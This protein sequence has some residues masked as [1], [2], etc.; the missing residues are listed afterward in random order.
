MPLVRSRAVYIS[1]SSGHS[2]ATPQD[3]RR[4]R[5]RSAKAHQVV[6]RRVEHDA[7]WETAAMRT[8]LE[9]A[10]DMREAAKRGTDIRRHIQPRP[11]TAPR[12]ERLGCAMT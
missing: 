9:G 10:L 2:P 4:G 8:Q 12:R 3:R 1:L 6:A 7:Y 11:S 5:S